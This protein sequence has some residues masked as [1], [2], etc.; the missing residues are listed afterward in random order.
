M[1]QTKKFT[2][3]RDTF[4]KTWFF[5]KSNCTDTFEQSPTMHDYFGARQIFQLSHLKG[6]GPS[7]SEHL[8]F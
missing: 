3:K 4:L 6:N 5:Q 7:I 8:N 2:V 1:C